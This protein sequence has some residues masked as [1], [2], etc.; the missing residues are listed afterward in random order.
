MKDWLDSLD[1]SQL[2]SVIRLLGKTSQPPVLHRYRSVSDW[3]IKEIA[4]H[5]VHV[6][7]LE[8]MNDPFEH[9][10]PL[11]IDRERLEVSFETFCRKEYGMDEASIAREWS[12]VDDAKVGSIP[13]AFRSHLEN[14]GLVCFSATPLSNRMWGYYASS[15]RGICIGYDTRY[16]PFQLTF[17][18][19][20]ED[21]KEPLEIVDAWQTDCTKFCDHL[22]RRKGEEWKFEQEYRLPIGPIPDD[23]TR[24]LPVDPHSIVEIR[25]GVKIERSF[26]SKVM[27]AISK[28]PVRPRIIQMEC[29][30]DRFQLTETMID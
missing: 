28:L 6:A 19:I 13:D 30:Y 21:P 10:A 15:H 9:R 4:N 3:T 2:E 17:P 25:L 18:V 5:E 11:S 14:S 23:H 20:Y 16:Q 8:D 27:K 7:R 26:K 29:D 12:E 24:L 22:A 1:E